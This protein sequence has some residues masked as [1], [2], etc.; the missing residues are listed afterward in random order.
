[1]RPSLIPEDVWEQIN[2]LS[3]KESSDEVISLE[4]TTAS[5]EE[6]AAVHEVVKRCFEKKIVVNTVNR[7]DKKYMEF[8]K[9]TKIC[10]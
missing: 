7:D 5:K 1:M 8:K 4:V 9:Y 6:R 10:K 3:E 2:L